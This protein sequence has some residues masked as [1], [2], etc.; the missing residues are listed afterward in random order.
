MI[1]GALPSS[2]RDPSGFLFESNGV[3]LRQVNSCYSEEY[4]HF[5]RSGLYDA[6][7]EDGLLVPHTEVAAEGDL[8]PEAWKVLR[9]ERVPFVSYPYEWSFHE[10]KAAA[11]TTLKIERRALEFGMTLKDASA[12]NIQF[13][14]GRPVLIDT[15]SF[16]RRE[17]GEPWEA[18]R[19]FC[20]HFLAP[21]ALMGRTEPRLSQWFRIGIDGVPLDLASRLLPRA[22][23]LSFSLFS[24]VHLHARAQKRF[25]GRQ[26]DGVPRARPMGRY[27]LEALLASLEGA[28]ERQEW[29]PSGSTWSEY[30]DSTN[31]APE[32][33]EEKKRLVRDYVARVAPNIVWDLGANVGLFSRVAAETARYVVAFD[34]DAASV[35]RNYLQVVERG[36]R[37]LLPLVVD[38]TNPSGGIGW[39]NRERASLADRGPADLALALALVHH[40]A[41][42]NNVPL[43]S[44]AE[45]FAGVA[46]SLVIEFVP[47]TDSQV[48][49]MLSTR[50]DVFPS[51]DREGFERAFARFFATEQRA[52]VRGTERALYLMRRR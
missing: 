28:V 45:F 47:K 29:H 52:D 34:N 46:R 38:L 11:R 24:H 33:L 41:I 26:G 10:L 3:L 18:Y 15:L 2:F 37:N 13:L 21:L 31:Y 8:A 44:V 27:G 7:V 12:Y 25:E 16:R 50:E 49:R 6:L 22:S 14:E 32:A 35:D 17:P 48:R 30:Y 43:G 36:E 20:Q 51:Y 9:P 1:P 5:V 42:G 4:E 40:L 19:Q 39:A 23:W